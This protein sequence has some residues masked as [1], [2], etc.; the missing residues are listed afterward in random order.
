M[1]EVADTEFG[2]QVAIRVAD[3]R[4]LSALAGLRRAWLEERLGYPVEDPGFE[5]SFAQWW[6]VEMPRRTF[7]I[8]EVG[9]PRSGYTAVG[10]INVL[11]IVHMPRP[12]ARGGR[13]GHVGNAFVLASFSDRGVPAA[14]L[15]A[16]VEHA[17]ARRFRRLLLAPTAGSAPFYRRAGFAPAGDG[18][19]MLDPSTLPQ[20]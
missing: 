9:S 18:L 14:L 3:E 20:A 19:L 5:A 1:A 16:V 12:G 13:I 2:Q 7:W 11:E 4:D 17:K 15:E 8:A 10:S 6:R